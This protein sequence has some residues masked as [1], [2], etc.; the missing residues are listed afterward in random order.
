[1]QRDPFKHHRYPAEVILL[2]VRWYCRYP[3]SYRDVRD[4]LGER[5]I[6]VDATTVFRWVQKFGPEIAK[7]SFSRRTW[8]GQSWHIDETNVR[9]AAAW[10]Y[11]WRAVDQCGQLIDFRLTK[12]R[13]T[14]AARAF[15]RQA[16]D[17]ARLYQP[18]AIFTDKAQS[19]AEVIWE[20]NQR[21]GAG[22]EILH[23]DRKWRNNKIE[24][25]HAALTRIT[26]P[27]KGLQSLRTANATL[28]G[29]EAMRTIKRGQV[30]GKPAGVLGEI[31]FVNS[32]FRLAA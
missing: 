23:C 7:Q 31:L 4:M 18:R 27:G 28:Q 20:I 17:N 2:A 30:H 25:D 11:L 16:M 1:M 9:I 19:Y 12:R 22:D 10:C 24:S 32:L 3:L 8:R 13:D 14:Q 21:R 5:G 26:D 6:N 15:L 29:V